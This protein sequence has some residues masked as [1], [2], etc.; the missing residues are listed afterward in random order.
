MTSVSHF[1]NKDDGVACLSYELLKQIL[2]DNHEDI[3][4]VSVKS[5][6]RSQYTISGKDGNLNKKIS[7]TDFP[8]SVGLYVASLLHALEPSEQSD[9]DKGIW[10][11]LFGK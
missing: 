1:V 9:K 10:N 2:D 4:W 8:R 3:E 5:K 11:R 6:L 7:R